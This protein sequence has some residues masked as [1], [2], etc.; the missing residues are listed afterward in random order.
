MTHLPRHKL[1]PLACLSVDVV[2]L[3]LEVGQV[4]P[5]ATHVRQ[6][7]LEGLLLTVLQ[8]LQFRAI[9]Y[10]RGFDQVL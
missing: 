4:D 1:S 9:Q 7:D 5:V 2:Q 10:L 6:G 3:L 8:E